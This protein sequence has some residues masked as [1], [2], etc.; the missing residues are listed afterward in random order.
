M[1][2]SQNPLIFVFAYPA[3]EFKSSFLQKMAIYLEVG[4]LLHCIAISTAGLSIY[5]FK[6]FLNAYI[7]GNTIELAIFGYMFFHAATIPIFAELDALSRFQNYKLMKDLIY[8]YGFRLRFIKTF[9]Y[10]KCQREAALFAARDLGYKSQ[11]LEYFKACGYKWY[12]VLPDF[13]WSHPKYLLTKSF[14]SNTFFAKTYH[15][16]YFIT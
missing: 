15:P 4:R 12:H 8:R 6:F 3:K 1:N 13:I 9:R 5:F 10:T 11:I 14:W 2:H 7:H 16:K